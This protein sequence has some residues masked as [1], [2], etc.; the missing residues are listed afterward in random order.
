M[1]RF[2]ILK[3][4]EDYVPCL[5]MALT[6]EEEEMVREEVEGRSFPG[7]L[8]LRR[9]QFPLFEIASNPTIPLQAVREHRFNLIERA[10]TI[11]GSRGERRFEL[12]ER[13]QDLANQEIQFQNTSWVSD[14]A[15]SSATFTTL[16]DGIRDEI[17]RDILSRMENIARNLIIAQNQI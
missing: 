8:Q 4:P 17:D 7:S 3:L 16:V 10:A 5:S 2:K 13:S 11:T 6:P 14:P 15:D 1:N 9:V 12:I